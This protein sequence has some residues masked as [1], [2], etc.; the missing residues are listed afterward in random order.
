MEQLTYSLTYSFHRDRDLDDSQMH[1]S[2]PSLSCFCSLSFSLLICRYIPLV[3][4][5]RLQA[6]HAF[7]LCSHC[8]CIVASSSLCYR[9]VTLGH[10]AISFPLLLLRTLFFY[11][12]IIVLRLPLSIFTPSIFSLSFLDIRGCHT[13]VY[14]NPDIEAAVTLLRCRYR[15]GGQVTT[16]SHQRR[17]RPRRKRACR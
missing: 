14:M 17:R 11:L 10:R 15:Y 1:I 7:A 5:H 3:S 2:R 16:V 4:Q 13:S 12:V 6:F 8:H 9:T